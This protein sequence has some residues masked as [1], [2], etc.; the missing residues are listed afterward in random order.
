MA[1]YVRNR[2]CPCPRCRLRGVMGGAILVTLG[3]LF[4]LNENNIVSFDKTFPVLLIVIGL[5]LFAGHNASTEGHIQPYWLG[6]QPPHVAPGQNDP[7]QPGAGGGQ[8]G[9]GPEVKS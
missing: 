5:L 8:T 9:A 6:G 4:L 7:R 1:I 3:V 2:S